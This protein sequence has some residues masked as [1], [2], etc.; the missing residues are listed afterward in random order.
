MSRLVISLCLISVCLASAKK[1]T[2]RIVGGN[3]AFARQFPFAAAIYVRKDDGTY[4]C[5]GTLINNQWVLTSAHCVQNAV[6]FTIQLGSNTLQGNDTNRIVLS[7]NEYVL[8]PDFNPETLQNDIGLVKFRMPVE[9]TDYVTQIYAMPTFSLQN[10]ATAV[11]IG[12]G[13]TSDEESSLSNELRYA[14]LTTVSNAECQ[15]IYG[16]QITDN[17]V[18]VS[19][20]YNEG[21]CI[22]DMGSPLVQ[23]V[24]R[25]FYLHVG[26]ASFISGNGCESTDPS[27][28][29]RTFSYMDWIKNVTTT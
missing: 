13:Q 17:M 27:G 5:G 15:Q 10:G 21:T 9:Y 22:G 14:D 8:N 11:A 25:G 29:T 4:F 1:P 6:S 12:W 24:G 28:Y 19:G 3:E 20:N 23:H 2:S 7:T 18:C 26:V 16:N